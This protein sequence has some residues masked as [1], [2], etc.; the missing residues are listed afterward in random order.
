MEVTEEHRP[1]ADARAQGDDR[2]AFDRFVEAVYVTVSRPFFFFGCIGIVVVWLVSAPLWA[3]LKA[4]QYVIHTIASVITLLL[5][6]LL[7][8]AARRSD[9]AAQ[10]KLNVIAE[11]LSALMES[12]AEEDPELGKAV[13]RLRDSVCLEERH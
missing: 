9:E 4:W 12:R 1:A 7:E 10:E 2:S 5:L 13:K 3:D 8:N 6:A 11:A